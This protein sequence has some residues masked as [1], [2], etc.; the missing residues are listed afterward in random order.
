MTRGLLTLLLTALCCGAALDVP[1][2]FLLGV[3]KSSTTFISKLLIRNPSLCCGRAKEPHYFDSIEHYHNNSA[4][5]EELRGR[6]IKNFKKCPLGGHNMTFDA[7]PLTWLMPHRIVEAYSPSQL[8][9]KKF[10][11][12]LRH[13]VDREYSWYN[14]QLRSCLHQMRTRPF[15]DDDKRHQIYSELIGLKI[16]SK[17]LN[18]EEMFMKYNTTA[19]VLELLAL[20]N[21]KSFREYAIPPENLRGDSSYAT[22]LKKWL[23]IIRRDQLL[24]LNFRSSID[25]ITAVLNI[26]SEFLELKVPWKK[27][28]KVPS[29]VSS[30]VKGSKLDC[31]TANALNGY[32]IRENSGLVEFINEDVSA[33]PRPTAEPKFSPLES[34]YMCT[35]R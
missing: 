33:G 6:Y 1:G 13:P 29:V 11:V 10:I 4:K 3:Q 22:I 2:F 9:A 18:P 14:H 20:S 27:D 34:D 25:N 26:V 31:E 35:A 23:S 12:I 24:V 8:A 7:T 5:R 21:L 32:F 28:F 30:F 15:T 19:S 17:I 16:C